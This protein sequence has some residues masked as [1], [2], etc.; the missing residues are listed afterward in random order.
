MD[1]TLLPPTHILTH[2]SHLSLL[3]SALPK[4]RYDF[5]TALSPY[6]VHHR[7]TYRPLPPLDGSSPIS[8]LPDEILLSIFSWLD[9]EDLLALRLVSSRFGQVAL[10][11]SLHRTLTLTSLP[12][13]PLPKL[14]VRLLP[15]VRNLHLHLFPYPLIQHSSCSSN[16]PSAIIS[17]MISQ[18][19]SNQLRSLSLPFSAPYLPSADLEEVLRK[20]GDGIE[21]LDLRG[22]ALSG[23]IGVEI[24]FSQLMMKNLQE[25]DLGFTSITS[26]PA[27]STFG[28][29]LQQ[30]SLA[31]CP[32]L[33]EGSL[34]TFLRE[35]PGSIKRLDLSRLDQ[36]PFEVL[37]D[38]RVVNVGKGK[39][40]A[41]KEIRVV[42][43]DHLT[44][45]DVRGLKRHWED[46]RRAVCATGKAPA[47][48]RLASEERISGEEKILGEDEPHAPEIKYGLLSPPITPDSE[49]RFSSSRSSSSS[50][51]STSGS[52]SPFTP[53]TSISSSPP[54][55][56]RHPFLSSLSGVKIQAGHGLP[57]TPSSLRRQS[58]KVGYD[59]GNDDA[60]E[61]ED[62]E[63]RVNVVHSAILESEDEDGYRRFIGEVVGGTLG[64][65]I[66]GGDAGGL[67]DGGGYVEV[68]R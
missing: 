41:L 47:G 2:H 37:W 20:V 54:N 6:H 28:G 1:I 60:G 7:R 68:D 33:S 4:D 61:D 36:I 55:S 43:I 10:S 23:N 3:P 26:L 25:V 65:G 46:Q 59:R 12:P 29:K 34:R 62:A 64:F 32:A 17:S 51:T 22:S 44:R 56:Y 63:T 40:T 19:P 9:L 35:L 30:I 45:R 18:I 38:M 15:A 14:M 24:I 50:S 31:S 49:Y 8:N 57:P 52:A 11:N 5:P 58:N 21:K 53:A 67:D 66:D 39:V 27:P 42:G 13:H 48:D 16:S